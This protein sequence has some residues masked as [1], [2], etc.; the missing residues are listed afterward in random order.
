[1]T[2]IDTGYRIKQMFLIITRM[3]KRKNGDGISRLIS[4]KVGM[5]DTHE[6][7]EEYAGCLQ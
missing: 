1:M 7:D 3:T 6:P 5:I 4:K 2:N